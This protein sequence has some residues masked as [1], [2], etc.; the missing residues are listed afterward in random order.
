MIKAR[1]KYQIYELNTRDLQLP[2]FVGHDIYENLTLTV[3]EDEQ[4]FEGAYIETSSRKFFEWLKVDGFQDLREIRE[5]EGRNLEALKCQDL[6]LKIP[7]IPRY[8][9]FTLII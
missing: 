7:G 3:I 4:V 5:L 6:Y 9:L 1:V 8:V 2:D